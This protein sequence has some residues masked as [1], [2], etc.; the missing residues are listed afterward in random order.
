MILNG[1]TTIPTSSFPY[2]EIGPINFSNLNF[3]RTEQV[4]YYY[5]YAD[6]SSTTPVLLS[7]VHQIY[8][9]AIALVSI[10]VCLAAVFWVAWLITRRVKKPVSY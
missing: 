5:G 7:E 4:D 6:P 8:D 10:F 1:T 3:V 9:P 2:H